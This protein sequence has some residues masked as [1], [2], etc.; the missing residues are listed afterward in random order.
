[1]TCSRGRT[2]RELT[3]TDLILMT[4]LT[5]PNIRQPNI[6]PSPYSYGEDMSAILPR[7]KTWEKRF[8]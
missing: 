7:F 5:N 6:L 4:S 2:Q 8:F 1:M 3:C